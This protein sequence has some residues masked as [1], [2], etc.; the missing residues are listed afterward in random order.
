M[1]MNEAGGLGD[2]G[3]TGDGSEG[4]NS[5]PPIDGADSNDS[6]YVGPEWAKD[7]KLT[8]EKDILSDPALGP[9][10]DLNSLVKSYVHAQR[11][12][13]QKG[14]LIPTENATKEEWDTFYQKIGVPLEEQKY[15]DSFKYNKETDSIGEEFHKEFAKQAH[16]L[17][18]SPKQAQELYNFFNTKTKETSENFMTETS[19]NMQRELDD[20]MST[21]GPEGYQVK[22]T[23]ASSFL[24]ENADPEFLSYLAES[25]LGKNA[26]LV[27]AFMKMADKFYKEDPIPN[28]SDSNYGRAPQD[29]E[30]EINQ[31]IGNFDDPY[32]KTGHP[33][34]N[35]RVGEVQEWFEKLDKIQ[36]RA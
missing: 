25:G 14:V 2:A 3:Q 32:H 22:L 16:A 35:R 17:R 20:L 13:G 24:K 6:P 12:I 23:K 28:P 4:T 8:V 19:A 18:V 7:L 34:H 11:K 36:K 33:D 27:N 9:I 15:L 30:R 1:L 31:V 5:N 10:S 26:K 21:M 29:L